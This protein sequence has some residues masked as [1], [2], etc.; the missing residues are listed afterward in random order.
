MVQLRGNFT[1]FSS[2]SWKKS[3]KSKTFN[4]RN[5]L[6]TINQ[7]DVVIILYNSILYL[8]KI[9]HIIIRTHYWF[10]IHKNK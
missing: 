4:P 1:E 7:L 3:G 2:F 6:F 8:P 5:V 9:V 10:Q